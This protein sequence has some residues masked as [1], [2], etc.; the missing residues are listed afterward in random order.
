[1]KRMNKILMLCALASSLFLSACYGSYYVTARPAEPYYVRPVAPY[2]GAIWIPGE[3]VWNGG[4]YI[5][6]NGHWAR[7][8]VGRVYIAGH[9]QQGP[10]GYFWIK[11]Y[12][13]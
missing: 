6:I 4:R 1:M 10:R 3:W 9:W 7:P 2:E 12:W 8:R 5:Y 13:R 11:G